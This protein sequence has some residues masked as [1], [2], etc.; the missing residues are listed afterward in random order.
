MKP[1]LQ[2][3]LKMIQDDPWKGSDFAPQ[4]A[5]E[6]QESCASQ[7]DLERKTKELEALTDQL[8]KLLDNPLLPQDLRNKLKDMLMKA[9]DSDQLKKWLDSLM[10]ELDKFL[11]QMDTLPSEQAEDLMDQLKQCETPEQALQFME[12][13]MN[14][15]IPR[16]REAFRDRMKTIFGHSPSN[17]ELF[18]PLQA[19][20]EANRS[21]A[22]PW[23]QTL[24]SREFIEKL[25]TLKKKPDEASLKTVFDEFNNKFKKDR[26]SSIDKW[27]A[28]LKKK[29][30]TNVE[31]IKR[32]V[33]DSLSHIPFGD[34]KLIEKQPITDLQNWCIRQPNW[35][36][37]M[38]SLDE[39]I[40]LTSEYRA[41]AEDWRKFGENRFQSF[42]KKL[43]ELV[44]EF[45]HEFKVHTP[46]I[47]FSLEFHEESVS[48]LQESF[49]VFC[50]AAQ[51]SLKEV[52]EDVVSNW[53]G[54]ESKYILVHWVSLYQ[55]YQM[56]TVQLPEEDTIWTQK[57]FKEKC[58]FLNENQT[59]VKLVEM[60]DKVNK[61]RSDRLAL[62]VLLEEVE[63]RCQR[64]TKRALVDTKPVGFG[65]DQ[66]Q[67]WLM[68]RKEPSISSN[69]THQYE[70]NMVDDRIQ[71]KFNE[72]YIPWKSI[73]ACL[74][75]SPPGKPGTCRV[76]LAKGQQPDQM[77][78]FT[79]HIQ[80]G[81]D[82]ETS[83]HC[84]STVPLTSLFE[85]SGLNHGSGKDY[86]DIQKIAPNYKYDFAAQYGP[87]N[88]II[89]QSRK[90]EVDDMWVLEEYKTQVVV[91][92]GVSG[93][94]KTYFLLRPG[95]FRQSQ[96]AKVIEAIAKQ[97]DPKGTEKSWMLYILELVG[98][99]EMESMYPFT[100][101]ATKKQVMETIHEAILSR[102]TMPTS[103]NP[104]SSRSHIVIGFGCGP[105]SYIFVDVAGNEYPFSCQNNPSLINKFRTI[106]NS[107]DAKGLK[108][109]KADLNL[110]FTHM[111]LSD[112]S[113]QLVYSVNEKVEPLSV[114]SVQPIAKQSLTSPSWNMVWFD[115]SIDGRV[116][117]IPKE[118]EERQVILNQSQHNL[119]MF[120]TK[121]KSEFRKNTVWDF[122]EK[123]LR[124]NTKAGPYC[125]SSFSTGWKYVDE[126]EMNEFLKSDVLQYLKKIDILWIPK[127]EHFHYWKNEVAWAKQGSAA[128]LSKG[129]CMKLHIIHRFYVMNS[130]PAPTAIISNLQ[131]FFESISS[132]IYLSYF[133]RNE[134]LWIPYCEDRRE[135]GNFINQSLSDFRSF[136]GEWQLAQVLSGQEDRRVIRLPHLPECEYVQTHLLH[137]LKESRQVGTDMTNSLIAQSIWTIVN[138]FR[139][140]DLGDIMNAKSLLDAGTRITLINMVF[141]R[142]EDY[143]QRPL[144]P[145]MD[146]FEL[147]RTC[148]DW[149][150]LSK[151]AKWSDAKTQE[152]YAR[153]LHEFYRHDLFH[154]NVNLDEESRKNSMAELDQIRQNAGSDALQK[155]RDI[156]SHY[157]N[158]VNATHLMGSMQFI[159]DIIHLNILIPKCRIRW[160]DVINESILVLTTI[161][162]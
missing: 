57:E 53:T 133:S 1:K 42:V 160:Q 123:G 35:E 111:A 85:I 136:M 82:S 64:A 60:F 158:K 59:Q 22:E 118:P 78:K 65:T 149:E 24:H 159:Q 144:Y 132:P 52:V 125:I 107:K 47:Q 86:V 116:V 32:K 10:P 39:F 6:L 152:K 104:A 30:S 79:L 162:G 100:N 67:I 108:S 148:V 20:F 55:L 34:W 4:L 40:G 98:D 29:F 51:Q 50:K 147:R 69:H 129:N 46:S 25:Q 80:V 37:K 17:I 140:E 130:M 3:A 124:N 150:A 15:E 9:K 99:K 54:I 19:W 146:T 151:M 75:P 95:D 14:E 102:K 127:D 121:W 5:K 13:A 83:F 122:V 12:Y 8:K 154:E 157:E 120:L 137:E 156:L 105:Y 43:Q 68:V 87:F 93:T 7:D 92:Y 66:T 128:V 94:G 109:Y 138:Q 48:K 63:D 61:L 72:Q 119:H 114:E 41:N 145:Y 135:E 74:N 31:E 49:L 90:D 73:S 44:D 45:L 142:D 113:G 71:L 36:G 23:D 21:V 117:S 28:F 112:K 153:E 84:Y 76:Y 110:T 134:H 126:K 103:N 88:R 115:R 97:T 16:L 58:E 18:H 101:T 62:Q 155:C 2:K 27:C 89:D 143:F 139:D 26:E 161:G 70:W 141:F 131:T 56:A 91:S 77:K 38:L 33:L 106:A 96:C 11:R 81:D